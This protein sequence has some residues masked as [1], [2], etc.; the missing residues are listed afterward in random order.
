MEA[1]NYEFNGEATSMASRE[2]MRGETTDTANGETTSG[3]TTGVANGLYL[4]RV[5]AVKLRGLVP[6][7]LQLKILFQDL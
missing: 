6:E 2:A 4:W 1:S 5:F 3:E 7:I